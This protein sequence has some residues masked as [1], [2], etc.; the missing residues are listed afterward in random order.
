MI[1]LLPNHVAN[2]IAAGEVVQRP[3]SALKE[4]MENA[5]DAKAKN[6]KIIIENAGK[7]LIQVIDDGHGMDEV[8]AR[9]C[10]ERHSTSKIRKAEDL[11]TL[12]TKG[13]RG[14]ALASI[15]AIAQVE[16]KTK[17]NNSDIGVQ[18]TI[19]GSEV[20][21][22]EACACSEGSSFSIKNLFF[23]VPARRN[24]LKSDRS[25]YRFIHDE[26]IR[27]AL[28]HPEIS[29]SL[30]HNNKQQYKLPKEHIRQRLVRVY[31]KN[32]NTKLVPVEE[33]TDIV[34]ISGFIC[35]PE[36][37][38]KSRGE[39]FFFVNNRFIKSPYMNHAVVSAMEGLL[40]VNHHPSYFLFLEVDPTKIDVNI[41]PTK[42][43]IKFQD[44]RNIY[45][46]IRS[47]IKH[48]LGQYN[49]A[50]SID[51]SINPKYQVPILSKDKS[52]KTPKIDVNP[53]FN[54][55]DKKISKSSNKL[56]PHSLS[57]RNKPHKEKH[58]EAIYEEI[59]DEMNLA[60]PEIGT[61]QKSLEEEFDIEFKK[62]TI[63]IK[64]RFILT[65]IKT[66][67]IIIDQQRAH[68]RILYEFYLKSLLN[69]SPVSQQLLFPKDIQLSPADTNVLEEIMDDIIGL[70]FDLTISSKNCITINGLPFNTNEK[71]VTEI[72]D[73]IIETYKNQS[74]GWKEDGKKNIAKKLAQTNAIKIGKIMPE[75]EMI[76]L[77]DD[78]FL[79]K[80][81]YVSIYN[82]P[83]T[84]FLNLNE[85]IKRFE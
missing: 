69:Q 9:M 57:E 43:E 10:F 76:Q 70:G 46:I 8:D 44:E 29:F 27:L 66:G 1:T 67:F 50:P 12:T 47:A 21:N 39:Q 33:K 85:L 64:N 63:Q 16:L 37:A 72:I 34:T 84:L 35:K 2:Q 45:A 61:Q 83:T 38:K 30:T 18:I 58:W 11:F 65:Q 68:E 52:V 31:G 41:H 74:D 28:A 40:Q 49:I 53:D 22:Q 4:L 24:F 23:N 14:E 20:N 56:R 55:F 6:I 82:K 62:F 15:A 19:E 25:E 78:L 36:F 59:Q 42:T 13:F 32:Y 73:G 26:F 60:I 80:M 75:K 81:P 3:S 17:K 5:I 79:C 54:P 48:S 51:F 7:T 71:N 77:V